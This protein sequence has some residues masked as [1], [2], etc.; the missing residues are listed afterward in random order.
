MV[1]RCGTDFWG[2]A[3][4][5]EAQRHLLCRRRRA[6][7]RTWEV[8]HRGPKMLF[9]GFDFRRRWPVSCA[10]GPSRCDAREACRE[11]QGYSFRCEDEDAFGNAASFTSADRSCLPPAFQDVL[12]IGVPCVSNQP[13]T[14][15][16]PS[17]KNI[18][19]I[20]RVIMT[21]HITRSLSRI[22]TRC[23][24]PG[25]SYERVDIYRFDSPRQRDVQGHGR[26]NQTVDAAG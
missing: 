13:N 20:M 11:R 9:D 1:V 5:L 6:Q 25:L 19:T 7:V 18:A 4:H 21:I 26:G 8:K 22:L 14:S 17:S 23:G 10:T 15:R 12:K 3:P 2:P 16:A 24:L